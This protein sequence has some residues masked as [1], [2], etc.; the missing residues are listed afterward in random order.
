MLSMLIRLDIPIDYD[1]LMAVPETFLNKHNPEQFEIVNG[2]NRY[3]LFGFEDLNEDIRQRHSH[4]CNINGEA[5]FFR[6]VIRRKGVTEN[7]N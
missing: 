6:V 5:K 3:I 4:A 7:E 1:G 2:L